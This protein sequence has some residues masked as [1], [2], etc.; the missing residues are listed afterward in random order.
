MIITHDLCF[1]DF[2]VWEGLAGGAPGKSLP[3]QDYV[4]YS[5]TYIPTISLV[6]YSK[7]EMRTIKIDISPENFLGFVNINGTLVFYICNITG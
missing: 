3:V 5:S 6:D 7:G 1:Y 4:L 2:I